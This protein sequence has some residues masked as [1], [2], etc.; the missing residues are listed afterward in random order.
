MADQLSASDREE[1]RELF[2]SIDSD[3][4]GAI[5][6]DELGEMMELLGRPMSREKLQKMMSEVDTDGGGSIDFEE[7]CQLVVNQSANEVKLTPLEDAKRAFKMFDTDGSG[8]IDASELGNALRAMG[9]KVSDE[10]V[11][12]MLAQADD[13]GTGIGST[14]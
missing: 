3:G 10:E 4:G 6:L 5:D 12:E 14:H 9:Q 7:F 13:D 11:K 8:T 2:N 1:F